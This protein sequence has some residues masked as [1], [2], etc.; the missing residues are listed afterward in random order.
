PGE[1]VEP[2]TPR[3]SILVPKPKQKGPDL[4][5]LFILA[6]GL[7]FEPRLTESESVVLPLDDP[8]S[9]LADG[10]PPSRLALGELSSATCLA[11]ADLLAL[12]L[13]RIARHVSGIAQRF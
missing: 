10:P 7:G 13:A 9:W 11:E 4:R 6:G 12:D 2:R 8:P 1:F 5:A 3:F